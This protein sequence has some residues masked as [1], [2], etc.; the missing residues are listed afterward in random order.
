MKRK[1]EGGRRGGTEEGAHA[2][3]VA[4]R[5]SLALSHP[6]SLLPV[7]SGSSQARGAPKFLSL[8]PGPRWG[9]PVPA[10]QAREAPRGEPRAL[11][12][13]DRPR[14]LPSGGGPGLHRRPG[15]CLTEALTPRSG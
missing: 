5:F 14:A 2:A 3:V 10:G 12:R 1:R 13:R 6:G 8:A 11:S 15:R 4:P 9:S 7:P